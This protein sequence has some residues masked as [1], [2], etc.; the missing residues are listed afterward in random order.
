MEE[1]EAGA[2]DEREEDDG[3]DEPATLDLSSQVLSR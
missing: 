2:E 1:N 3:D